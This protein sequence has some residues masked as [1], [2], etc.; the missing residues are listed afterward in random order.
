MAAP[1]KVSVQAITNALLLWRG[2][3]SAASRALGLSRNGLYQRIIRLRLDLAR[4]RNAAPARSVVPFNVDTMVSTL[5]TVSTVPTK[6][7]GVS[8]RTDGREHLAQRHGGAIVTTGPEGRRFPPVQ[9][10]QNTPA[11]D[12]ERPL[13][14]KTV[15]RRPEP[16]Q[17]RPDLRERIQQMV[18]SIQ[19]RFGV[20]SSVN[21][22]LEQL[23][24]EKVEEWFT[25]I[26]AERPASKS[27]GRRAARGGAESGGGGAE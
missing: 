16:L 9:Q 25:G 8:N 17:L 4:F 14:V 18:Y 20:A 7:G 2:D 24:E 26:M 10:E 19:A 3:V 27:A 22:V 23:V 15:A 13:P 11:A 5:R 12:E 21:L 6:Q 1:P